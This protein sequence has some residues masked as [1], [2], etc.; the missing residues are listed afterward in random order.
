MHEQD[1]LVSG[2]QM[3]VVDEP[4]L[5]LQLFDETILLQS[6]LKQ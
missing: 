3:E 2:D 5:I 6:I 4:S 1:N